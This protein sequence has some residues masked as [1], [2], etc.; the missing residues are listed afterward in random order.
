MVVREGYDKW[1]LFIQ[2]TYHINK[3]TSLD[4]ELIYDVVVGEIAAGVLLLSQFISMVRENILKK[5]LYHVNIVT[6]WLT[7]PYKFCIWRRR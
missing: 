1:H 7:L 3:S 6:P 5:W 2:E 4:S